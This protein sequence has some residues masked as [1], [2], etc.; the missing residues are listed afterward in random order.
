[1]RPAT[2]SSARFE[3]VTETR[4]AVVIRMHGKPGETADARQRGVVVYVPSHG[5]PA[6]VA[7]QLHRIA[8][9]LERRRG[10]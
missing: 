8:D 10:E 3:L 2:V 1:L 7:R 4:D 6:N 5:E 9:V